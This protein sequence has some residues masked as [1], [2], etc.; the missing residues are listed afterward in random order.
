MQWLTVTRQQPFSRDLAVLEESMSRV[1]LSFL[2]REVRN[3][4]LHV[5]CPGF[6]TLATISNLS[7]MLQAPKYHPA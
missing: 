6:R 4:G 5:M 1:A 7:S 3:L 2:K